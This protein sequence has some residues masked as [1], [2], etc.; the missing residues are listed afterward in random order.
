MLRKTLILLGDWASLYLALF[1]MIR[2]SYG[3]GWLEA[4]GAHL[5]PYSFIF[6]IWI[7][8]L[9]AL[10]LYEARFFRFNLDTLRSIGASIAVASLTSITAFY[11]FPP[12]LIHPRRDMLLFMPIFMLL[13]ILWRWGIYRALRGG[14]KT[15]LVF[16]GGG[17]EVKE[18]Q[19][20][21]KENPQ[22]GYINR[23]RVELK[24]RYIRSIQKKINE[25][26]VNLVVI[27]TPVHNPEFTR[28]LFSL[29]SGKIAVVDLEEFY[30]RTLNKVSPS[31]ITD[32]WFIKNLENITFGAYRLTKRTSDIVLAIG[33]LALISFFSPLIA[34][35][36]KLDSRGPILFKQQRIGKDGLPYWLYKFRTMQ[37]LSPD[38]SAEER[39]PIYARPGDARIT[40]VGEILRK[41]HIDELPQLWNVLMGSM[42]FVGPR[43]IRPEFVEK[44][45]KSIPYYDMR[46]LVKPGL[47]GWAQ[48]NYGY[49]ITIKD[50]YIKLRYDI[51]YAK[52]QSFILDI[53]IILKTIKSILI[54][55]GQ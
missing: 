53:A 16:L 11:A 23:G 9:Y 21:F 19:Q 54:R 26:G 51:Y 1:I 35:A 46:H 29:L 7:T 55:R 36:I 44:L 45:R 43:P 20:Y 33:G 24:G 12:G 5:R 47:T 49:G 27:N 50:E 41:T 39:G 28:N 48:I 18:L 3:A 40:R 14:V 37:A 22:L 52:K 17:T 8:V 4:W 13:L 30:E 25:E 6:P 38:G 34:L 15:N 32:T 42:S 2:L 10:Y 31:I